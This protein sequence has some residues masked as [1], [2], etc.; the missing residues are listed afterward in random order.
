MG[1]AN[2][3]LQ[4]DMKEKPSH[5]LSGPGTLALALACFL[6][7]SPAS[8]HAQA[9][10]TCSASCPF[11]MRCDQNGHCVRD[12]AAGAPVQRGAEP[13]EPPG[14]GAYEHDGLLVRVTLGPAGAWIDERAEVELLEA[15]RARTREASLD[16][17]GAGFALG[18]DVGFSLGAHFAWH[19]RLAQC[20]LPD[21]QLE[22]S[23]PEGRG[24]SAR[25]LALLAPGLS[26]FGPLGLY[27]AAAAGV[28]FTRRQRYEGEAGLGD[29][30]FGL[31]LDLGIEG[32]VA[33][34]FALGGVVRGW[35]SSTQASSAEGDRSQRALALALSLSLTYH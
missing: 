18:L 29:A 28:A 24:D 32:W 4:R 19:A 12:P 6:L 11:G 25:T 22:G 20:V 31:N 13:A 33:E 3:I 1:Y 8:G 21:P 2:R 9:I 5:A 15:G 26:Y 35:W 27:A 10:D 30:G 7:R 16:V 23:D 14:A 17:S 34:Q